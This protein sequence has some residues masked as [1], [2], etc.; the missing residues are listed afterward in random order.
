MKKR[1]KRQNPEQK[2]KNGTNPE[3][4]EIANEYSTI[5]KTKKQ[6]ARNSQPVKSKS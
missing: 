1:S 2:T 6:N 5:E 3:H 4:Y